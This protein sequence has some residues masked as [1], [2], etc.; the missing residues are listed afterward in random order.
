MKW[1]LLGLW[2]CRSLAMP[3]FYSTS[4]HVYHDHEN[5]KIVYYV[6]RDSTIKL[7]DNGVPMFNMA[8]TNKPTVGPVDGEMI[9]T[10]QLKESD[11]QTNELKY[12]RE[13]GYDVRLLNVTQTNIIGERWYIGKI[14]APSFI[15]P[16]KSFEISAD[17][18]FSQ[19]IVDGHL[20]YNN[21]FK[22]GLFEFWYRIEGI[23]SY[24][25]AVVTIDEVAVLDRL[26]QKFGRHKNYPIER[27][28]IFGLISGMLKD[29]L[30]SFKKEKGNKEHVE[31]VIKNHL[32]DRF[33]V[34]QDSRVGKM[35]YL[36][37]EQIKPSEN[38]GTLKLYGRYNVSQD[39]RI[40]LSTEAVVHKPELFNR[41]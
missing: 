32:L 3:M 21:G 17:T 7:Y 29:K 31:Q 8:Y 19:S 1:L 23:T 38:G 22:W 25:N 26:L 20:I 40:L 9:V 24:L 12:Y 10:F 37:S 15:D 14:V 39:M 13:R 4:D 5:E 30:I 27:T 11:T 2:T 41:Y 35:K 36:L 18:A 28:E 34:V 6:P 33:F 16:A